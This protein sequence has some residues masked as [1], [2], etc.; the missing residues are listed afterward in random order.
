LIQI[1]KG[2]HVRNVELEMMKSEDCIRRE[3]GYRGAPAVG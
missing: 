1:G 3:L 2:R